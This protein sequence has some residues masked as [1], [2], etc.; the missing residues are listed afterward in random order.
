LV[1][2]E[3]DSLVYCRY[4]IGFGSMFQFAD[5]GVTVTPLE[6]S[7][8]LISD[9][10]AIMPFKDAKHYF[11][12]DQ[13][14]RLHS[15]PFEPE[16]IEWLRNVKKYPEQDIKIHI[17]QRYCPHMMLMRNLIMNG[18]T[19]ISENIPVRLQR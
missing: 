16:F 1:E 3:Y 9:I 7:Y 5:V 15:T 13:Y 17:E 10:F 6:E 4:D 2:D 18:V 11:L 19:F 14:E 8:N 12:Y